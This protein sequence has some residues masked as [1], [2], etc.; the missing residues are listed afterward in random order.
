MN[1]TGVTS[2]KAAVVTA[3]TG[4]PAAEI[5]LPG[6]PASVRAARRF[7]A[8]SLPGC[9]RADDLVLAA[10]ELASNA[11]SHSASGEG[12]AFT[13]RVR[14]APRWARVE[15]ADAGPALLPPGRLNGWGL[16]IIAAVAD[17]SGAV[18]AP[19]GARTSFAEVTW[20]PP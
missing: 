7:T 1:R 13:V 14:R 9:P 15:V 6:I 5:V 3:S 8:A 17:R 18:I 10:S 20:P 19:D 4:L 16:D 11:I 2:L 12:G